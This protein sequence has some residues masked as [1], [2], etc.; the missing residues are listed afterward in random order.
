MFLHLQGL[1][2]AH[3]CLLNHAGGVN[4]S[5][6]SYEYKKGANLVTVP[7]E[8]RAK[9]VIIIYHVTLQIKEH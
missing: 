6:K 3:T 8:A 5:V 7:R 1:W 2:E 9:G 4:S